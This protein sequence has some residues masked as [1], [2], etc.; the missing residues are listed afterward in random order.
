MRYFVLG[1]LITLGLAFYWPKYFVSLKMRQADVLATVFSSKGSNEWIS[2]KSLSHQTPQKALSLRMNESI[3]TGTDGEMILRFKR[4]AEIRILPST[5]ITLIRKA[6]STL[7]ALRKGEIEV[8]R[9]GETNSV[10][11]S[12]GGQDKPLQEYHS[13]NF[14]SSLWIDSQTLDTMKSVTPI[15]PPTNTVNA[16]LEGEGMAAPILNSNFKSVAR[17][18]KSP[19]NFSND[20]LLSMSDKQVKD[21]ESQIRAMISDRISR[22]KNHLFRC[23]SSLMQKKN[24]VEDAPHGKINLHFT[25][26]NQGK[27]EDLMVLNS[28]IN[29]K[30]FQSCLIQVINRTD[31]QPFQGQKVS[32]L[33]PLR[34]DKDLE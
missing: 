7:I 32:T 9:E 30:K 12:Q 10:L 2:K 22:Q 25:V 28:E 3:A 27:V 29:D 15:T 24:S 33:L 31:F 14:E 23:Y 13:P 16:A 6:N 1:G 26:N 8:I 5:F 18:E 17:N 19:I 11:I 4:G 21:F 20:P 34:F